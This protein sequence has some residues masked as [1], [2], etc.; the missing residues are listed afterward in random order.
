MYLVDT[1]SVIISLK[2][3]WKHEFFRLPKNTIFGDY[4][5]ILNYK[6]RECYSSG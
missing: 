3:K 1:G 2:E 6:S 5:I 4:Q